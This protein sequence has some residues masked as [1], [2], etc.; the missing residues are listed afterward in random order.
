MNW[1]D[2]VIIGI[3]SLSVIV[4]IFRG[5]VREALS[6]ATWVVA[7][8]VAFSFSNIVAGW[9]ANDIESPFARTM[10]GFVMVL[11]VM[12]LIGALINHFATLAV[13][14]V[15]MTGTDRA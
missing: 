1:V 10:I 15:G 2:I 5:F 9:F 14:K 4:S 3:V 12:L 7:L 13:K 6:L 8:V 11:A